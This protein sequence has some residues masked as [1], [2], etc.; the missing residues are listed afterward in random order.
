MVSNILKLIDDHEKYRKNTLNL[1][2]SENVISPDVRKALSSDLNSRYSLILDG[3][4]AYGGTRYSERIVL[5]TENLAKDVYG[6]E[7][8]EVRALGGH[9]A[10]E[11]IIVSLIKRKESIL[12]IAEKDGGYTGYSQNY[13]PTM[14][15]FLSYNIPYNNE[16]QEIDFE[17]LEGTMREVNPRLIML[18]QSFFVKPYDLKKL[19]YMADEYNSYLAYDA[20]HVMGLLGGGQ[21]QPDILEYCDVVFGSTHK[22]FFGPQGGIILTNDDKIN[23]KIRENLTWKTI[24]NFHLSRVAGLGVVLKEKKK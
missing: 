22:T 14:F 19:R 7:F 6:S 4:N 12:A 21:F 15:S 3:E 18:G 8:A 16:T 5:E 23:R 20:S 24:D 9:I 10:A 13:L 1:Q 2:A 11:I 17:K